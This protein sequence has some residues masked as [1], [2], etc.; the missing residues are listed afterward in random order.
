VSAPGPRRPTLDSVTLAALADWQVEVVDESPSTNAA[1]AARARS[2]AAEGLVLVAE[3]QTAGR[4]RLDRVWLT[5]PR[6]ALTFS[7]LLRPAVD[8]R[9]WPWLPLLTGV[10]VVEAVRAAGGPVCSLKWPNDVLV[11]GRKLAGVLA[12]G[13]PQEGWAIIGIGVNAAVELDALPQELRGTATTL[14]LARSDLPAALDRLLRALEQRLA[15]PMG[16]T[17][18][19]LRARDAL[20]DAPIAWGG[21][22]GVGAGITDEGTLRVRLAD[23]R[24]TVLDAGEVHLLRSAAARTSPPT[25]SSPRGRGR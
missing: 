17:L 13:R 9:W 20:L 23:G 1:L 11:D 25:T 2:G 19:A 6:A 16:D 22:Q 15:E 3:H 21:G 7:V 14:G 12:E 5:P 18:T 8:D 10:A 24:E 4:G